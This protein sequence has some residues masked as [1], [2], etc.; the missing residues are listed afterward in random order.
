MLAQVQA[1]LELEVHILAFRRTHGTYLLTKYE[2]QTPT[3]LGER[4]PY[5]LDR[6]CCQN[7][8]IP[9]PDCNS[10]LVSAFP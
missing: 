1:K 2:G 8:K 3:Q 9:F 5:S 7:P 10:F 4:E 6:I